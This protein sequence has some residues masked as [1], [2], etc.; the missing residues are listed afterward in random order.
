MKSGLIFLTLLCTISSAF[1]QN[2]SVVDKF[3]GGFS[4]VSDVEMNK[5]GSRFYLLESVVDSVWLNDNLIIDGPFTDPLYGSTY[6]ISV[7]SN[8]NIDFIENFRFNFGDLVCSDSSLFV[9]LSFNNDTLFVS[10]TFFINSASFPGHNLLALEYNYS[11]E[12][13]NFKH[14][15]LEKQ[16]AFQIKKAIYNNGQIFLSGEFYKDT[17]YLDNHFIIPDYGNADIFIAKMTKSFEVT[18][19]KEF[20]HKGHDYIND[21]YCGSNGNII[22]TGDFGSS[23][24]FCSED[25]LINEF[26]LLNTVDM[27]IG[28]LSSDGQCDWMRQIKDKS[29]VS[30]IGSVVLSDGRVVVAGNYYGIRADFGDTMLINPTESTN[31]FV[32]NYSSDGE[33]SSA[34]QFNGEKLIE[35]RGLSI[36]NSDVIWSSGYFESDSLDIGGTVFSSNGNVDALLIQYKDINQPGNAFVYGGSGTDYFNKIERCING[37]LLAVLMSNSDT[38]NIENI[39]YKNPSGYINTYILKIEQKTSST[40]YKNY[41]RPQLEIYPNPILSDRVV[42]YSFISESP[43]DGRFF[44]YSIDGKLI[45]TWDVLEAHGELSTSN[46]IAGLYL[47]KFINTQGDVIVRQLIF[48]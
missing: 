32:A 46:L 25:T 4:T 35:N 24:I 18:W 31:G 7:N 21:I 43:I 37:S 30:G 17:F 40:E 34:W 16:N 33:F 3:T 27:F 10:D 48:H 12:L 38:I 8:G 15:K 39:S 1:A 36:T 9:F 6:L 26:A 11:G 47:I 45:N 41:S 44:L 19:L 5:S 29:S 22:F 42:K 23:Y 14:W 20:G 2:I 28:Q 13:I